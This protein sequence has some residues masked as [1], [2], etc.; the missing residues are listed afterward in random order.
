MIALNARNAVAHRAPPKKSP[1]AVAPSIAFAALALMHSICGQLTGAVE[2]HE[3]EIVK[4]KEIRMP[5]Q[6]I[7]AVIRVVADEAGLTVPE[8]ASPRRAR[9]SAWPRQVAMTLVKD[10]TPHSL[11]VI[12]RH[13]GGRDHTTVMHAVKR[14]RQRIAEG[15]GETI[16]LYEAAKRRLQG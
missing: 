10:L 14:V 3:A 13:F 11:P 7:A 6:Q 4:L 1:D 8:F 5:S 12:G 15:H 9:A 2:A 16:A